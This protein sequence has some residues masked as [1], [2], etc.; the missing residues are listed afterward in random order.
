MYA[1]ILVPIDGSAG[2]KEAIAHGVEVARAMGSTVVFLFVMDTFGAQHEGIV[3]TAEALQ[4]LTAE[5]QAIVDGA[6][7]VGELAEGTPADEI[8]RRSADSDLVV[9]GSRGRGVLRWL[10]VGSVTQ[11]VL[12]RVARPIL[13]V[14]H[15]H[16]SKSA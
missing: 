1:R 15:Q 10:T 6:S 12:H 13:V 8:V 11:S 5:G 4:A 14:R 2:S 9:M 3:T 7:A 16:G